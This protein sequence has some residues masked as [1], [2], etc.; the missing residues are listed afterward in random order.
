MRVCQ[1][2]RHFLKTYLR[3][4]AQLWTWAVRRW[5][6]LPL[7]QHHLSHPAM[8]SASSTSTRCQAAVPVRTSRALEL[9]TAAS[10]LAHAP[11]ILL[12]QAP[13]FAHLVPQVPSRR[14]EANLQ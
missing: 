10:V 1:L 4:S 7:Q 9:L 5:F 12:A 2:L 3:E 14:P 13:Q 6:P 8:A 11:K